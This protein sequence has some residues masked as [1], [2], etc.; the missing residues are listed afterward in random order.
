VGITTGVIIVGNIGSER[1][2][3]YTVLGSTVNLAS[4]LQ[5]MAPLDGVLVSSRTCA[6]AK[7]AVSCCSPQHIR[8]RGFA[9]DVTVYEIQPDTC[10]DETLSAELPELEA[11][12]P[13]TSVKSS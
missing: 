9:G 7:G 1:R 4:R 12:A 13:V 3:E 11:Q 5:S 10:E 6:L 2:M 8:V